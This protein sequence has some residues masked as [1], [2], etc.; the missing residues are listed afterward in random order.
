MLRK[1][2]GISLAAFGL[3][4]AGAAQ[5]D[6]P[7]VYGDNT[8][9]LAMG[10]SVTAGYG[11][12]PQTE[13][14][15]FLLYEGGAY[16]R[17]TNT[18]F[19]NIA[20]PGATSAQVLSHQVPLAT[21]GTFPADVITMTV[22]GNDLF[23]ILDEGADPGTVIANYQGN[24]ATILGQL[25]VALPETRIYVANVYAIH[26]F[27]VPVDTL[28]GV[29]NQVIEGV[30]AFSNATACGGRAKV[31]DVHTA[32]AG[33]QEGSLLYNRPGAHPSEPHPSNAG[34]RLIARTFL[35]AR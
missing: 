24:L 6:I 29:F 2:L 15:A 21:S 18:I 4:L 27:V 35:E 33:S 5:A 9:Y 32:F 30:V 25:C 23:T 31:V 28:I 16:D 26:D 3:A 34:H 20:L 17:M 10:D 8:R 1:S 19:A 22:G 13:G 14:Y 12:T 7:W 11:A